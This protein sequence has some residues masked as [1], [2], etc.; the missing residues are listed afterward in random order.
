M[1]S[2]GALELRNAVGVTIAFHGIGAIRSIEIGDILVNLYL[3]N[4]LEGALS[5]VYARIHGRRAIR[6]FPLT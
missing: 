2:R 4:P 3:G 1:N 6:H 5:N